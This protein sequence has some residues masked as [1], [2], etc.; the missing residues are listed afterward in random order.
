SP[1]EL[2]DIYLA[3]ATG[4]A[5]IRVT[6]GGTDAFYK[7]V[8]LP[9]EFVSFQDDQGKPVWARVYRPRTPHPAHPAVLEIHE[10][11]YAQAVH[12]AF[13]G[14]SAHGGPLYAQYLA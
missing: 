8:W 9:S 7:I 11:G 12:K 14:S 13:G 1:R 5:P 3:P 10:A 6:K 4:A 2:D